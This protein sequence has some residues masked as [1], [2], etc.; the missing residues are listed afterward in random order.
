VRRYVGQ[1]I[2]RL[3][4]LG[5]AGARNA[6]LGHLREPFVIWLDDDEEFFS[7]PALGQTFTSTPL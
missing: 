7:V 4:E 2:Q 3:A 6:L 1:Q 5:L